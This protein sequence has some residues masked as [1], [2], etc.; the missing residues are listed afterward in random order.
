MKIGICQVCGS[1]ST[2]TCKVCGA[3]VCI[4]CSNTA[5]CKLCEGKKKV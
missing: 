1:I 3:M 4:K 5:G 2:Q